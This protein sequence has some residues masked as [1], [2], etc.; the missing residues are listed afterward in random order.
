[1]VCPLCGKKLEIKQINL[2]TAILLCPDL[3]CP[4]PVGTECLQIQRKLEDID[5]DRDVM[6]LPEPKCEP[7]EFQNINSPFN[8]LTGKKEENEVFTALDEEISRLSQS[9]QT[10]YNKEFNVME[11]ITEGHKSELNGCHSNSTNVNSTEFNF[12]I[13]GLLDFL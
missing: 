12:D 5:K 8:D 13:D 9:S 3:S 10:D 11:V 4:Y 1:M 6:I 2:D 7:C